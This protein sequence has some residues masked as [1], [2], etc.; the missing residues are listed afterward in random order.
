MYNIYKDSEKIGQTADKTFV[1]DGL[2]PDTEYTLGVTKVEGDK[3]SAVTTVT[4]RTQ[5]VEE[6]LPNT[7][8][9]TVEEGVTTHS[10]DVSA[11][12]VGGGYYELP[13]G[14]RVRGKEAALA[15]LNP[16]G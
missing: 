11:Y 10:D 9:G 15:L 14:E 6:E 12:H 4:T 1:V 8:E 16:E 5:S 7:D 3:E 2:Q 13:S